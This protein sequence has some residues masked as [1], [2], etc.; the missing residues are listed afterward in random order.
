[1]ALGYFKNLET[2]VLRMPYKGENESISMFIFLPK[3]TPTAIDELLSKLTP[4]ILDDVF[5][6]DHYGRII[7]SFPK[8]SIDKISKLEKVR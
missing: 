5:N 3:S 8:F 7:V 4:D 6:Y 2:N 1:M